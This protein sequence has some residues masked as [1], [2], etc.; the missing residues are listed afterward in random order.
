MSQWIFDLCLCRQSRQKQG[1][2]PMTMMMNRYR[3]HSPNLHQ[4]RHLALNEILFFLARLFYVSQQINQALKNVALVDV[5][6]QIEP[7]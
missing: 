5:V 7:R 2:H 6:G 3:L 4:L 1:Q